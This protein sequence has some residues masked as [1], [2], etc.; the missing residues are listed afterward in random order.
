MFGFRRSKGLQFQIQSLHFKG[1]HLLMV[2]LFTEAK[3]SP[4]RL[5]RRIS[6]TMISSSARSMAL[7]LIQRIH[8]FDFFSCKNHTFFC[9][10]V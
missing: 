2:K 6:L 9:N 7:A 1:I 10:L 3:A 5:L 4:L 8:F